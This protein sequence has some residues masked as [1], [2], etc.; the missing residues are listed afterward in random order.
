MITMRNEVEAESLRI[1][2]VVEYEDNE[3]TQKKLSQFLMTTKLKDAENIW[4]SFKKKS[5][6]GK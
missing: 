5:I 6:F 2:N 1:R 4:L 3:L